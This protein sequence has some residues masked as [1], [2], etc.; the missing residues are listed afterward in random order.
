M[1]TDTEKPADIRH[2]PTATIEFSYFDSKYN[3]KLSTYRYDTQIRAHSL[4]G[5]SFKSHGPIRPGTTICPSVSNLALN[6]IEKSFWHEVPAIR[7]AEVK[8]CRQ[9]PDSDPYAYEIGVKYI[10][11]YH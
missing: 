5:L 6:G 10:E 2:M 8:S 1:R 7:I 4:E 11:S 9:L 3:N